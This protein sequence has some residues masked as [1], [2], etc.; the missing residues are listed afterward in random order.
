MTPRRWSTFAAGTSLTFAAAINVA[1]AANADEGPAT[2]DPWVSITPEGYYRF[3]LP[4][5]AV[6]E[7]VG[8][9][10][11]TVELQGNIGPAGTWSDLAADLQGTE[12]VTTVGPLAPGLYHY[13]YTATLVDRTKVSFKEPS[14]PRAVTSQENWSTLFVPG[15]S[16]GWFADVE[17]PGAVVEL[18]LSGPHGERSAFAWTPPGLSPEDAESLPILVL[19]SDATQ[20]A[21]EW[22]E[23]GR[24]PQVLDNLTAAGEIEPMLV[25]MAD[26]NVDDPRR[27][28]FE[29][30]LPAVQRTFPAADDGAPLALAGIGSGAAHALDSLAARSGEV[31]AVGVLSPGKDA[32]DPVLS[33]DGDLTPELLRVYVGNVLDPTYN[34]THALL[35]AL[36]AAGVPHHFDG[37][38]PGSGGT[39]ETWRSALRDFA[40]RAFTD[41]V[42][43]GPRD[44]HL[45]LDGPYEP[46]SDVSTPHVDA[47]G[48]VTFETGPQWADAKDVTVWGNWAPNGAWFRIPMS[49][50]GDRWRLSLGP[51]DGFYY[52]RYVVDGEDQKDPADTVNT[53]TEVS[54]LFVPGQTDRLLADVPEGQGGALEVLTYSSTV[55]AGERKAYVW[56]PPGYDPERAEPY[57]VLYLNH[58]GGQSW[59]DWVE[60]GRAQQIFDNLTLEGAVVP[61]V[62]VMG[63]GNV[64]DFPTELLENLAPAVEA[65]FHVS[66]EGSHRAIA[67]LSMG[68]MHTLTTWLTRPGEFA[69]V[70]AFSGFFFQDPTFDAAEVNAATTLARIYTGDSADFT[71]ENTLGLMAM[72]DERG[73]EYEFP[74]V[75]P[76]PHGFDT[77]QANLIDFAPLLFQDLD[78]ASDDGAADEA[79]GAA[80]ENGA[81]GDGGSASTARWPWVVAG[82]AAL[83]AIIA[84]ALLRNRRQT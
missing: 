13:Q 33:S 1:P 44:G 9:E 59:G 74:G 29:G 32:V 35:E 31:T 63:D 21:R 51:L 61:M 77:W 7:I 23:L 27:E 65:D 20:S 18:D 48:I 73:V 70:G 15:E 50:V 3:A 79:P 14:I 11:V 45:P 71:Y 83:A 75:T 10:P 60:V 28:L 17:S 36:D 12:Y 49:R 6:R 69:Y 76:G 57:P 55:A 22:I 4:H 38:T 47:N 25:V 30:I 68:A 72:L 43:G 52:Y 64:S 62:V 56:T 40:S 80:D 34:S 8:A 82:L 37:V 24:A 54:P 58:G 66:T 67:G 81:P 39:W 84:A 78:D 5:G 26:A 42:V 2:A 16:A 19:L 53:L 46:P 41:A